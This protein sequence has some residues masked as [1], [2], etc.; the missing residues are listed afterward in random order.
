M[1][2]KE[3]LVIIVTFN[4]K[5][6]L[7]RCLG[8]CLRSTVKNDIFIVDNGSIDGTQASINKEFP[9]VIFHQAP[10]NLGFG[11]AN[12]LGLQY[13]ID[14]GYK[15]VYLL[16]QDAWV[17]EDTFKILIETQNKHPEFGIISPLQL[18]ANMQHL[19]FYFRD[20]ASKHY[21]GNDIF[22]DLLFERKR[23]LVEVHG[24]MAAHWMIS[25]SCLL[26]VGGFSD[27][28]EHYGEDN[29]YSSRAIYKGFKNGICLSAKAV[30]DRENR[31]TSYRRMIF[32][33][34]I[35]TMVKAN[36]LKTERILMLLMRNLL[37]SC[38]KS[39]KGFSIYPLKCA[40][41]LLTK[42]RTILQCR[43]QSQKDCAF[44]TITHQ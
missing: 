30:H 33:D 40:I 22:E 11:R 1:N 17:M 25:R 32:M 27:S 4:A 21:N 37:F 43:E 2:D 29:N 10:Y 14:K 44:L 6:W 9:Q 24:V 5:P 35:Q 15:H 16:N 18:Q 20:I 13:A 34:S 36:D 23:G 8:S 7:A 39:L 26:K 31:K 12:N 41:N 3:L 28:F 42:Y 38:S 19:D